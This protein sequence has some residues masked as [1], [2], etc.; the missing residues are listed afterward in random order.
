MQNLVVINDGQ[1]IIQ[2]GYQTYHDTFENFILDGGEKL[3]DEIQS[4][5]Y[6]QTI[7]TCSINGQAFQ[8]FPNEYAE[9]VLSLIS[10]LSEAFEERKTVREETERIESEEA[11]RIEREQEEAERVANLTKQEKD[12]LALFLA[13]EERAQAVSNITVEVDG[14]VFDG[15]EASQSRMGRTIAAA[16]ALGLDLETEKRTWVLADNSVVEVTIA[17]L[18]QV[19]KLAG[20]A[21]TALWIVPYTDN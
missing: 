10:T 2:Y 4:L 15:N 19:L 21:Q 14:M 8:A 6:N 11:E 17:Q 3:P 20:D 13:K 5:D 18:A 16:V 1:V 7:K 12:S 9:R